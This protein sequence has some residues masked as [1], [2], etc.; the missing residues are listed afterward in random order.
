MGTPP[1][2]FS[3]PLQP[4]TQ[5]AIMPQR[6]SPAASPPREQQPFIQP[7]ETYQ[8]DPSA[9]ELAQL[10]E[11]HAQLEARRKRLI[12][13]EEI[14]KEQAALSQRMQTMQQMG[15]SQ[16]GGMAV[17]DAGSGNV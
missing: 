2:N 4:D 7:V 3:T 6:H 11:Q 12:E 5:V 16:P 8:S 15:N 17:K 13:L 14:E 1:F 10:R 9:D